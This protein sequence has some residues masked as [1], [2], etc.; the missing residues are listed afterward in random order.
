MKGPCQGSRSPSSVATMLISKSVAMCPAL[1]CDLVQR[2]SVL[3][4]S[5]LVPSIKG[6]NSYLSRRSP[7]VLSESISEGTSHVPFLSALT[8]VQSS[9]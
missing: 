8:L 4:R 7:N 2:G 1:G 9:R 6:P 3:D 5:S